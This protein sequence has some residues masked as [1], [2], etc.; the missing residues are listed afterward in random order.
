MEV[1]KID[2]HS[3]DAY[4]KYYDL[5]KKFMLIMMDKYGVMVVD[6][7]GFVLGLNRDNKTISQQ[8]V[9]EIAQSLKDLNNKLR[10]PKVQQEIILIIKES[11]PILQEGFLTFLKVG[12]AGANYIIKDM[13]TLVCNESPAAPICGIFK[14]IGNTIEFGNEL[15][16]STTESLN[17]YDQAKKWVD[18]LERKLDKINQTTEQFKDL[19]NNYNSKVQ[20]FGNKMSNLSKD[21]LNKYNEYAQNKLNKVSPFIPEAGKVQQGLNTLNQG[22]QSQIDSVNQNLKKVSTDINKSAQNYAD[23]VT[24]YNNQFKSNINSRLQPNTSVQPSLQPFTQKG[25]KYRIKTRKNG[26]IKKRTRKSIKH[27]KN[28]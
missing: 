25:G 7:M 13:I 18:N 10:D 21:K 5:L 27:F 19:G 23:N 9:D 26:H 16:E 4:L 28:L 1:E 3:R 11:E 2:N 22:M 24:N 12:S 17:V 15:L 8:S 20:S 14:L 6:W